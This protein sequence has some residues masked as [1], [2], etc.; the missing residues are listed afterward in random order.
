MSVFERHQSRHSTGVFFT[1]EPFK[2]LSPAWIIN[3]EKT[4]RVVTQKKTFT[5]SSPNNPRD[6]KALIFSLCGRLI[7]KLIYIY[8]YRFVVRQILIGCAHAKPKSVV[9]YKQIL[10]P[11]RHTG[12]TNKIRSGAGRFTQH[13]LLTIKHESRTCKC[14]SI[15]PLDAII[16]A[17]ENA[18]R[19]LKCASWD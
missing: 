4:D 17:P 18:P 8:I 16:Y 13:D 12:V 6:S 15:G 7:I 14:G 11:H 1:I 9:I 10:Q 2:Y 5:I 3:W 19:Y